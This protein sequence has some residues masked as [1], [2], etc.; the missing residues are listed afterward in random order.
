MNGHDTLLMKFILVMSETVILSEICPPESLPLLYVAQAI[1]P[2]RKA[3]G[4]NI[5]LVIICMCPANIYIIS[6]S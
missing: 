1:I 6:V 4:G 3:L 2:K 5:L